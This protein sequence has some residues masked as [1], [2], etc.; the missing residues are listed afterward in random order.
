MN[1]EKTRL[2]FDT[3][4]LIKDYQDFITKNEF[5]TDDKTLVDFN[6]ICINRKE[7]FFLY[8]KVLKM[9]IR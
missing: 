9:Q 6:A 5:V 3:T 1:F 8:L 7:I 4:K 2:K